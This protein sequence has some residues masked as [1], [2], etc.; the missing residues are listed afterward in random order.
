MLYIRSCSTT[1]QNC[2]KFHLVVWLL[3]GVKKTLVWSLKYD[4]HNTN[5]ELN[6]PCLER[7][8]HQRLA[9]STLSNQLFHAQTA[10]STLSNQ[11]FHAQTADLLGLDADGAGDA[12][13][14]VHLAE[15]VP[16]H[17]L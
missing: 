1:Y 9:G 12:G 3:F 11:L 16:V 5:K 4:L 13:R 8:I 14:A 17:A 6:K 10:G 7:E 15:H 2:L